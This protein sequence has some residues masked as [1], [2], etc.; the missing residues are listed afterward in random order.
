[1]PLPEL[2]SEFTSNG[3]KTYPQANL[4]LFLSPQ[5]DIPVGEVPDFCTDLGL[6]AF[7]PKDP[8]MMVVFKSMYATEIAGN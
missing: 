6:E 1:M 3:M 7:M 4:T 2:C 5:T 8:E